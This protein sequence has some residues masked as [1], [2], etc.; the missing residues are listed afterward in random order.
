MFLIKKHVGQMM[1]IS[2]PE[3]LC[4]VNS[5]YSL[6]LYLLHIEKDVNKTMFICGDGI[7]KDIFANLTYGFK[8]P[9]FKNRVVHNSYLMIYYLFSW[10]I[11]KPILKAKFKNSYGHDHLYFSNLLN[12]NYVTIEDGLGNYI[13]NGPKS[14]KLLKFFTDIDAPLG[15]CNKSKKVVLTGMR[16]VPVDLKYK[17]ET[18]NIYDSWS[19]LN[20]SDKGEISAVFNC[21]K[22]LLKFISGKDILITQPLSEDGYI[23]EKQ[24]TDAYQDL[25]SLT[26]IKSF[27]LKRHPRD[28]TKYKFTQTYSEINNAIPFELLT[29]NGVRFSKAVT[30]YS[31]SAENVKA[32]LIYIRGTKEIRLINDDIPKVDFKVIENENY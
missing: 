1:K 27:I 3:K 22:S 18:I 32:D 23:T 24:K 21:S 16:D 31:G 14:N 2:K 19:R 4:I 15:R 12:V 7:S 25:L 5:N 10:L 29:L 11:L 13:T 20:E 30:I 28:R 17:T 9:R 8:L 26:G 6:L